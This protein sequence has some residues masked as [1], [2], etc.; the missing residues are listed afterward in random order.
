MRRA[1][2]S[3]DGLSIGDA[4]GEG[5]T[6]D[7][8]DSDALRATFESDHPEQ[9]EK[10]LGRRPNRYGR[11]YPMATEQHENINRGRFTA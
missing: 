1:R 5:F 11:M 8:Q 10:Q 2:L 7:D 6:L 3:L 9:V 4:F